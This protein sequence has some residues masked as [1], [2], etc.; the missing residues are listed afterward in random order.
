[1]SA[2]GATRGTQSQIGDAFEQPWRNPRVRLARMSNAHVRLLNELRLTGAG[3]TNKVMAGELSR[4][5]RR[6]V[7]DLRL[8]E[9]RKDGLGAVVYPFEPRLARLATF[10]HRTSARVLWDVFETD[11]PRLEPL[12]DDVVSAVAEQA[13]RY[14]W[15]NARISVA[16]H[17]VSEFPAGERQ[18]VG[19]VKNGI[20]EGAAR[21]GMQIVLDPQS[22][23]V[24]FSVRGAENCLRISVDLAGRPMNQRGYRSGSG[25][26]PLREDLAAVLLMLGRYDPRSDVLVDPMAGSG[27][28][29]IEAASMALGMPV[30]VRPRRPAIASMPAFRELSAIGEKPLFPDAAPLVYASDVD[31]NACIAA[32]SASERAHVAEYVHVSTSDFRDVSPRAI[33]RTRHNSGLIVSNPPYGERLA[34]SDLVA[35]YRELGRFCRSFPGFRAAFL[36]ANREFETA[37]GMRPK[38][39]KPLSNGPLRGYFYSYEI[40]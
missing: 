12:F 36:V 34:S 18:I 35:L 33:S 28:I 14:L 19:T 10:Y 15:D 4:I 17:G 11:A 20:I 29:A 30:W 9:P 22:P 31:Q 2:R 13:E 8:P 3:G 32:K 38:I 5:S 37:F 39:K 21:S 27:T 23:D 25:P 24:L 1:V 26:A 40:E 16:A 6:A 7:P